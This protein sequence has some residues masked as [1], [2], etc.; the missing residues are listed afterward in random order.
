MS[1]VKNKLDTLDNKKKVLVYCHSGAR[2]AHIAG[3]LTRLVAPYFC[4]FFPLL[5]PSHW[6][7]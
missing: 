2:A 5:H 1:Q 4:Q 6:V 3:L 7:F